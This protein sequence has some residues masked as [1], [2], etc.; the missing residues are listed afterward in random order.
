MTPAIRINFDGTWKT[1]TGELISDFLLFFFPDLYKDIDFAYEPEFLEQEFFQIV[2]DLSTKNI[3]DKLV[4]LR[5]NSGEERWIFIHIEFQT[6]GDIRERMFTYYRRI[7]D[8]YGKEITALVIYTGASTPKKHDRY[9][10]IPKYGT[11]V[12]Y[13]FNSYIVSKQVEEDLLQDNNPFSIVVLANL[14]VNK[15]KRNFKK[16][17]K[18]KENLY[19]LAQKRGYSFEKTAQLFIFVKELMRLTPDLEEEYND[20]IITQQKNK[21]EMIEVSQSTKDLINALTKNVYGKTVEEAYKENS[22]QYTAVL[23]EKDNAERALIQAI[24]NFK[25]KMNLNAEQIGNML[26]LETAF[27]E[28]VLSNLEK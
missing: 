5:L 6:E 25:D 3:T 15:T 14:Y 16:R 4:K 21:K 2:E 19:E 10:S 1:I 28:K 20:F 26:S 11:G 18:F 23:K 17:L 12:I 27:V 13:F 7:L 22:E 9:E 8:R 24:I